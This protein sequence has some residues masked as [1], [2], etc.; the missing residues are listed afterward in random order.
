[1]SDV[2]RCRRC[3]RKRMDDEPPEVKQYK[4][5]AKCRI[6]ERQKKKL[7][8]PLAEETVLYGMKQFQQQ[9]Q[10]TSFLKDDFSYD[11][12]YKNTPNNNYHYNYV[13]DS[14]GST[15]GLNSAAIAATIPQT[16]NLN[17]QLVAQ[18]LYP[19]QS[20]QL[21]NEY[22]PVIKCEVCEGILDPDDE[23]TMNYQL[24]VDCYTNPFKLENVYED[25]N[26]FL[27]K[28]SENNNKDV[29][30]CVYLREVDKSFV[31][32]LNTI[33]HHNNEYK[34]RENVIDHL[35]KI[36]LEPI[37]AST[38]YTFISIT[39]NL[40]DSGSQTSVFKNKPIKAYYKCKDEVSNKMSCRSSL[41]M[42][43]NFTTNV[44]KIK[45]SHKAHNIF[46][47]YKPEFIRFLAQVVYDLK[48][49]EFDASSG[50]RVYT[51]IVEQDQFKD[52]IEGINKDVFIKEF[53]HLNKIIGDTNSKKV[54]QDVEIDPEV[55]EAIEP[56][57]V[58][59]SSV[60]TDKSDSDNES[61]Y[62]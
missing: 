1:M 20:T 46:K 17:Y 48:I 58:Y 56:P 22:S 39:S 10:N 24:C 4:T 30:N 32:S 29:M 6:I 60:L 43:Y 36:Y 21:P 37:I 15:S 62:D 53:H 41:F 13:Y 16:Y 59:D 18:K 5:C 42:D 52:I 45:F 51:E 9:N 14:N 26:E 34:F 38:T 2:R 33:V 3:K 40:R 57:Q 54:V 11:L 12:D 44:L 27:L 31:D 25:Y 23:L 7:R 61:G 49:D 47:F 35:S 8:K 50:E 28:L 55:L 19:L